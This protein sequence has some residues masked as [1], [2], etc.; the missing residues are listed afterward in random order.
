MDL[1]FEFCATTT[2][3]VPPATTAADVDGDYDDDDGTA[4]VELVDGSVTHRHTCHS[5]EQLTLARRR[6]MAHAHNIVSVL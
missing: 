6:Q 1:S 2:S 5:T 3:L 4:G